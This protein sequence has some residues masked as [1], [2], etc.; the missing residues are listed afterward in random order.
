MMGYTDRHGRFFLR[1]FTR[2]T[3]LYTEMIATGQ[4]IHGDA[5]R[6]LNFDQQES[7]IALQL[8]GADPKDLAVCAKTGARFGYNE[9]NLNI[10][11]PSKRVNSGQFGV[12]LMA[13]PI[14]VADCIK[15]MADVS[16]VPVTVK[17]RLGIYGSESYD[18]LHEFVNLIIDAGAES[19]IVHARTAV[20]G[21]LSPKENREIPPLR[22]DWVWRLKSEISSAKIVIN[23]GIN[24]LADANS[25][26]DYVDGVMIGRAAISNP[27]MLSGADQNIF[28]ESP[29]PII[30]EQV[31]ENMLRYIDTELNS[32]TRLGS[33]TRHMFGLFQGRPAARMWRRY[34]SEHSNSSDA[35]RDVVEKALSLMNETAHI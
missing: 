7:P 32:G 4:I 27:M 31:A 6:F 9:I 21:G 25:H 17:C 35:G 33:I 16:G 15:A 30:R 3:L 1:Q 29:M 34:L 19:I 11:C 28:G 20:L 23:G 26:L 5:S 10:G 18:Q 22:H 8:G 13:K 14:L 12:C 24:S 2:R